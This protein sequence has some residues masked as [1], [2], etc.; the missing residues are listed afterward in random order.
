MQKNTHVITQFFK[1]ADMLLLALCC[2]STI[3]G[4]VAISS[5]TLSYNTPTNNDNSVLIQTAS[6][7]LGLGLFALFTVIDID[8]IADRWAP[9][10]VFNVVFILLLIPFGVGGDETGNTAWLRF[11]G[12]GIQPAEVVK[13]TFIIIMAKHATYLKQYRDLSSPLS[14]AQLLAHFVFIF[15]LIVVVTGDLGSALVYMFI[16]VVM[17]FGAGVKLHW[18]A[19]GI[20]AVA[21][22]MPFLWTNF[23]SDN[24]IN[25]IMAPYNPNIDPTGDTVMWQA[26]QSKLALASGRFTGT[27]LYNGTQTQSN[28]LPA[29]HTD[30]IFS[31]IGEELGMLGCIIVVILLI[32]II[33]RCVQV[34]IKS[35]NTMNM[36]VCLGIAAIIAAQTLENIGMCIGVAPVIGVTLPFFSYGGSHIIALFAAM[37]IVSGI[38]FR[39]KPE[40]FRRYN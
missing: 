20:A 27:G 3:F 4:I 7:I 16:F 29:K 32:A 19:I 36:L 26:N 23:L 2:I 5:A 17:I 21:A 34:G 35:H 25:R 1:R 14:V 18:F 12:I 28:A 13:V 24:Q 9:L 11:L 8:I 33:I 6:F 30:F 31:V 37:G 22:V 15:G 39:P 38:K 10:F 40:R